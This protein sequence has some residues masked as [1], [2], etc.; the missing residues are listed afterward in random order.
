MY[1]PL[2]WSPTSVFFRLAFKTEKTKKI[3]SKKIIKL[4][5]KISYYQ[6]S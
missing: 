6:E 1:N 3:S 4:Q 2:Q 5:E